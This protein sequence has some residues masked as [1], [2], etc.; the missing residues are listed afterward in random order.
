MISDIFRSFNAY[1][2]AA[3]IIFK[4]WALKYLVVSA[5]ISLITLIAFIILIYQFGDN[6]TGPIMSWIAPE[7]GDSNIIVTILD[8]FIR[9]SLWLLLLLIFK[10]I[11]LIVTAP[12][13]S[14]LSESIEIRLT[15]N[16]IPKLGFRDQ[17]K[18]MVRGT[19][20]ALSNIIR[21]LFI[22][23][24]I[25][26]LSFIPGLA[27]FSTPILLI[28]QSYYAGFGNFD[29]FL[30]RRMGIRDTR[31]FMKR[32]KGLAIGNGFVFLSFLIIP[33]IGILLAPAL[34]TAAATIAALEV[35]E[36]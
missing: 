19:A 13:M 1:S 31:L 10:Y 7:K 3:S 11:I 20:L 17:I 5:I 35:L 26:L 21:E 24:P 29:F 23:I 2:R 25:M 34:S 16:T 36:D 18:S 30:E 8:W 12:V 15:S 6:L 9:I 33:L 28:I 14:L 22:S 4:P 27:L 32:Y